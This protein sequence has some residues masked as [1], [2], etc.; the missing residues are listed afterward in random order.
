MNYIDGYNVVC[1][2]C[3]WRPE[4]CEAQFHFLRLLR[5][6]KYEHVGFPIQW[7]IDSKSSFLLPLNWDLLKWVPF[8][9]HPFLQLHTI[10]FG[11]PLSNRNKQR[12]DIYCNNWKG[13]LNDILFK[14]RLCHI[15]MNDD[16]LAK[17]T[18][19]YY[20][21]RSCAIFYDLTRLKVALR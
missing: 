3:K 1:S 7:L 19:I 17:A 2:F 20:F 16:A 15:R 6:G 12:L 18:V 8:A 11:Y 10:T 21:F 9:A 13:R 4:Q 14:E 5:W